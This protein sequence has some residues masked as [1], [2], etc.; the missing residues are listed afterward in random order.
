[1][2]HHLPSRP[3][4][5]VLLDRRQP[6]LEVVRNRIQHFA[7]EELCGTD[8]EVTARHRRIANFDREDC[9]RLLSPLTLCF[10]S[11]PPNGRSK[12]APDYVIDH[13]IRGIVR[14]R[15]LPLVPLR[16]KIEIACLNTSVDWQLFDS[17]LSF[18]F[19]DRS[20]NFSSLAANGYKIGFGVAKPIFE[21]AF[22]D[23][24]K[25]TDLQ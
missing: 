14:T 22:V 8:E 4:L 10:L 6:I 18:V 20:P 1:M 3:V 21:E 13:I 2:S 5:G 25:V 23:A 17:C 12:G 15:N 11:C 19:R 7:S 16:F 9:L 24:P